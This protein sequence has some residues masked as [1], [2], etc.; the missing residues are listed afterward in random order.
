MKA[1]GTLLWLATAFYVAL[2][3]WLIHRSRKRR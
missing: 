1:L 2:M 3:A